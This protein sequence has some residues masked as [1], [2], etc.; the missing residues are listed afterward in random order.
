[1]RRL[2]LILTG[3]ALA[4]ALTGCHTAD[5]EPHVSQTAQAASG[6]ME[7]AEVNGTKITLTVDAARVGTN[8]LVVTTDDTEAT[9]AEAQVIMATMGHGEVVPLTRTAPGRF[10]ARTDAISMDGR[11]MIRVKHSGSAAGER[12]ASFHLNVKP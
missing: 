10:E 9:V 6:Y 8:W 5:H 1:M 3:A 11:W 2:A 12:V 7:S 4:A